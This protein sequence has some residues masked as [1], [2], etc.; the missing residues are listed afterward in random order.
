MKYLF[1][2]LAFLLM[3]SGLQA[4]PMRDLVPP[5]AAKDLLALVPGL[6]DKTV[7]ELTLAERAQLSDALSVKRQADMYVMRAGMAS[8][9][10][11]GLGQFMTASPSK[12]ASSW[13]RRLVS[14]APRWQAPGTLCPQT[15]VPRWAAATP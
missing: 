6:E 4:Q 11:P 3:F 15:S 1:S 14:W 12:A 2:A 13:S 7:A 5:F 10:L 8:F 9:A